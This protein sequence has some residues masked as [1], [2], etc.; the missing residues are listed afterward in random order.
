MTAILYS[1]GNGSF[2]PGT[3]SINVSAL[4]LRPG[5][6]SIFQPDLAFCAC[7][8]TSN[9]K[10]DLP[11]TSSVPRT[12]TE[13]FCEGLPGLNR[14]GLVGI[15]IASMV[16]GIQAMVEDHED[17]VGRD[18]I[19]TA[20]KD[21]RQ[22]VHER[23]KGLKGNKGLF[24]THAV[25]YRS[26]YGVR[27]KRFEQWTNKTGG[28]ATV[29]TQL[30]LVAWLCWSVFLFDHTR[31]PKYDDYGHKETEGYFLSGPGHPKLEYCGY[32]GVNAIF[33]VNLLAA[34]STVG[35]CFGVIFT[36]PVSLSAFGFGSAF[37]LQYG[38]QF[39]FILGAVFLVLT[40]CVPDYTA[41]MKE[42][43]DQQC[44][45]LW[46]WLGLSCLEGEVLPKHK[47][48][49]VSPRI[50]Q[51]WPEGGNH[52]YGGNPE[53]CCD[54][55]H[56]LHML[57]C[58]S[59]PAPVHN[60]C[61]SGKDDPEVNLCDCTWEDELDTFGYMS[62]SNPNPHIVLSQQPQSQVSDTRSTVYCVHTTPI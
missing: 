42:K 27:Q 60:L 10:T 17:D 23:T 30:V 34:F 40:W 13:Y 53:K 29:G 45:T 11:V 55:N 44:Y 52:V 4:P 12:E 57:S 47:K 36:L 62:L 41:I 5:V 21:T 14:L 50:V 8:L 35:A 33:Y 32:P 24:N 9:G 6:G 16:V 7:M 59:C 51:Q 49:E 54:R 48:G 18:G 39:G 2:P 31:L 37:M 56:Q 43:D 3:K 15:F 26:L 1:D 25:N 61:C 28:I 46:R 38:L 20:I 22:F 58:T 19:L